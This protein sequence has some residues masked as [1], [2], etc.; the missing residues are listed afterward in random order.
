MMKTAVTVNPS[1]PS[2]SNK[3]ST[4]I[5]TTSSLSSAS[6]TTSSTTRTHFPRMPVYES[7][8]AFKL[9]D[10]LSES[11]TVSLDFQD[12][13]G[14]TGGLLTS[15]LAAV[16]VQNV[17]DVPLPQGFESLA[18]LSSVIRDLPHC[19]RGRLLAEGFVPLYETSEVSVLKLQRIKNTVLVQSNA[20][21]RSLLHALRIPRRRLASAVDFLLHNAQKEPVVLIKQDSKRVFDILG[22]TPLTFWDTSSLKEHER[23]W[24]P[25]FRVVTSE[26][27]LDREEPRTVYAWNGSEYDLTQPIWQ[28]QPARASAS[29]QLVGANGV[30][31][32][33]VL[34]E[35]SDHGHPRTR[36][37]IPPGV[38]PALV[39]ALSILLQETCRRRQR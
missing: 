18:Q 4:L 16:A 37:V 2:N 32:G 12:T 9:P 39:L 38:D 13:H 21:G 10:E 23:E 29:M 6:S 27:S 3:A 28:A 7:N 25:W 17:A 20:T 30:V 35:T 11:S 24:Y 19:V 15:P 34:P 36:V 26:S 1:L 33:Q 22:T 5:T 31:V 14:P 8:R